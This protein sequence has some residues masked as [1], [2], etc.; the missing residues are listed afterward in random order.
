[1]RNC[2]F[3]S[4]FLL[5]GCIPM[6]TQPETPTAQVPST[7]FADARKPMPTRVNFAPASREASY[8]VLLIKDQLVA[9][10][11]RIGIKPYAVAIGSADPEV[12]H[13]GNSIYI[14]EGLVRQCATD[15]QLAAVLAFEMGRMISGREATIA[16]EIRQPDR[17]LPIRLPIAGGGMASEADPL[18]AI[19]LARH[20]RANP[21]HAQKLLRPNPQNVARTILEN[22]GYQR[23]ELD[24][25]LPLLA[26]AERYTTLESQFKGPSK[27]SEWKGP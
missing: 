5:V 3:L 14:S 27:Q 18:H 7:P 25:V 12:F 9:K 10:N 11:E 8:R 20:E 13:V 16:D 6:Q 4:L 15:N 21:K 1:M 24:G 17:P 26:A 19:E 23:T 22:A 2:S